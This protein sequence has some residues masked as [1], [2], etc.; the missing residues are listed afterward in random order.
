MGQLT[1]RSRN[2]RQ[3]DAP[4]LRHLNLSAALTYL[5]LTETIRRVWIVI[6]RPF[7]RHLLSA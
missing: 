4:R 7:F 2:D 1:V 3:A 6:D 5:V